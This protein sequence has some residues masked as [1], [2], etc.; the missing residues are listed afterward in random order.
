MTAPWAT[1]IASVNVDRDLDGPPHGIP[2]ST[3]SVENFAEAPT[4]RQR[5]LHRRNVV[6][7]WSEAMEKR[8]RKIYIDKWK[9]GRGTALE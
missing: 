4:F 1:R 3:L 7:K 2:K 6:L 9:G 8:A 5:P